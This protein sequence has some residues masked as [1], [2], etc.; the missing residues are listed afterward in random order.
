MLSLTTPH[1]FIRTVVSS[2]LQHQQHLWYLEVDAVTCDPEDQWFGN[3]VILAI[4]YVDVVNFGV[5]VNYLTY[6]NRKIQ[7]LGNF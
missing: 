1:W 4:G 5:G 7:F 3:L 2:D 6:Q